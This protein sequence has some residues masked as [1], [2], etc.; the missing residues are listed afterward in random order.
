M[1][2][3]DD[4]RYF[5]AVVKTGGLSAAARVLNVSQPTVGRRIAG[6]EAQ[7]GQEL[8]ER[9]GK[10]V[11]LTEYGKLFAK[12]I[13][14]LVETA[15]RL[16]KDLEGFGKKEHPP[17]RITSTDGLALYWLPEMLGRLHDDEPDIKFLILPGN[18]LEDLNKREADIAFRVKGD[19]VQ[20][21]IE[22]NILELK[23][24]LW[25]SSGYL[26]KNGVPEEMEGLASHSLIAFNESYMAMRHMKIFG[27]RNLSG[28][29]V[30]RSDNVPVQA[31]AVQAGIGI[32]IL[33]DYLANQLELQ[34]ISWNEKIS[35][36][37]FSM[38]THPTALAREEIY[39]VWSYFKSL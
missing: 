27:D 39:K 35:I 15:S 12:R 6:M 25:A 33:P 23:N 5:Q 13:E 22:E 24:S 30:F 19:P 18:Q 16:E 8:L 32:G 21:L 17:V 3:W 37:Q 36:T 34:K 14:P 4:Y 10:R 20:G 29:I 38:L 26:E 2:D 1:N 11:R 28:N 31:R 9:D 7:L